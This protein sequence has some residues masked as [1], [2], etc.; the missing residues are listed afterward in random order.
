MPR[1]YRVAVV[2][3]AHMHVN[4][5]MRRFAELP[6]VEMVAIA[7]TTPEVAEINTH[8]AS[9]RA[10]TIR[11]ALDEL[12]VQKHYDDWRE[13]LDKERPDI[14]INNSENNRHGEIV[15]ASAAHGAHVMVEK[16]MAASLYEALRM[17]R[18]CQRRGV[19]LSVNWPSTWDGRIRAM[20]RLID[21]G[22]IGRLWQVH[23]RYGSLGPLSYGSTH[24]GVRAATAMFT[25]EEKGVTWWHRAGNGGGA[26]L[27]Y[28]CYGANL[29]RWFFGGPAQAVFGM[30]MNANS[31]Y[32]SADDNAVLTVRFPEGMAVLEATWSCVDHLM[33][34]GPIAY[35]TEGSMRPEGDRGEGGVALVQGKG[36]EPKIVPADPFPRGRETLAKEFIHHIETG[37]P[38]HP[39]MDP[40][41]NLEAMAILDAG[42]RSADSGQ[43][44]LANSPYWTVADSAPRS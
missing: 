39:T 12:G 16:P 13:L 6:N 25:D 37:E 41:F 30:K 32:G 27:D 18:A 36:Q 9:S 35:G 15:E 19:K 44:E 3:V 26:L 1:T 10:H 21:E 24:P 33:P 5:L 40:D 17:A 28:C 14:V 22:A 43:L 23:T 29:S 42:I 4:E 31:H 7:D 20:K 8:S 38:L 2:G 11:T 34:T